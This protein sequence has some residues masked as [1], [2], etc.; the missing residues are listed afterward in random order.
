MRTD[1]SAHGMTRQKWARLRA[2]TNEQILAEARADPDALPVE[3]RDPRSLGPVGRV[4]LQSGFAGG[5]ACRK[6]SLRRRFASRL[7][8]CAI[9]SN[10]VASPTKQHKLISRLLP[11]NLKLYGVR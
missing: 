2:K 7:G 9:G 8:P 4:S 6:P 11:E 3:D 5:C 1:E 10:I